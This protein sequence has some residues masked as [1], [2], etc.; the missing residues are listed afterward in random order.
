MCQLK[1]LAI[2]KELGI[3]GFKASRGWLTRFL[4]RNGL[5]FRR[6]T[7]VAQWLPGDYEEKVVNFHRYVIN[8]RREHSY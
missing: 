7:T 8:L 6:K 1:A 3:T 4:N 2:S 5:G